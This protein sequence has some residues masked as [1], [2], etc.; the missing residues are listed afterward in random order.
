MRF[1]SVV[2]CLLLAACVSRPLVLPESAPRIVLLGEI[3]DHEQGHQLRVEWLQQ[4]L[5]KGWRPAI[6]LEQFDYEHQDLLSQAQATCADDV[7]C[8]VQVAK[9]SE[10][11]HWLYYYPVLQLAQ[12]YQL[13]L[14]AAN[15]SRTQASVLVRDAAAVPDMMPWLADALSQVDESWFK[16]MEAEVDMAHCGKLP[17]SLIPGMA[18]AQLARDAVMAHVLRQQADRGVVLLAGNGHVRRD[19]GVPVWLTQS[20]AIGFIEPGQ[21]SDYFDEVVVLAEQQREDPCGQL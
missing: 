5:D 19:L 17:E 3:H 16:A 2:L 7:S 15:F 1:I 11:W 6:A 9:G 21:Y 18:R 8:I 20:Y 10:R 12:Q 14:L 13:P 4:A